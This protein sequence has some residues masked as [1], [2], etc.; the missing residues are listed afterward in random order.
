MAAKVLYLKN[1]RFL[2]G[3]PVGLHTANL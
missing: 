1:V 2:L 3:H